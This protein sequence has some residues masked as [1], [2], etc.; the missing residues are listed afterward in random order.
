MWQK[1][2]TLKANSTPTDLEKIILQFASVSRLCIRPIKTHTLYWN[3]MKQIP[4][5][6]KG[7]IRRNCQM[8]ILLKLCKTSFENPINW[9]FTFDS[10][11]L[12]VGSYIM[13]SLLQWDNTK[14]PVQDTGRVQIVISINATC[15]TSTVFCELYVLWCWCSTKWKTILLCHY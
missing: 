12:F 1:F 8:K 3:C 14:E 4:M 2:C 15:L 6:R 11:P 5:K 9:S 7:S 10:F 13:L